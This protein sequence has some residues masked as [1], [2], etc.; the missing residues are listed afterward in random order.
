M[1]G[2]EKPEANDTSAELWSE[3]DENRLLELVD[4]ADNEE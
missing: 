3:E 4:R 2:F 1:S